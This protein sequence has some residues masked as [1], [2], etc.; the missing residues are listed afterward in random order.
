L[1][2][3]RDPLPSTRE[4]E[5]HLREHLQ[6]H[7][8]SVRPRGKREWIA[9]ISYPDYYW[10]RRRREGGPRPQ[11]YVVRYQG[12]DDEGRPQFALIVPENA[13]RALP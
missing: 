8:E 10:S 3:V 2:K 13:F 6:L 12:K 11:T 5:K 1:P 7:V 4:V 9:V